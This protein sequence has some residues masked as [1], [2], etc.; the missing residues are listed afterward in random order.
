MNETAKYVHD[1]T[2]L[3]RMFGVPPVNLEMLRGT[4]YFFRDPG[5]GYEKIMWLG[6]HYNLL[7]FDITLYQLWD[8]ITGNTFAAIFLAWIFDK[9][10][11]MIRRYMGERSIAQKTLIDERFLI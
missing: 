7:V 1:K 3:M 10:F 5:F 6:Q 11:T 2:K 8:I 4:P 9:L